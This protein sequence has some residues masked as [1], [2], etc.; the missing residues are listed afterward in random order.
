M[1]DDVDRKAINQKWSTNR[2]IE[3]AYKMFGNE[4]KCMRMVRKMQINSREINIAQKIGY[5]YKTC[6]NSL[7]MQHGWHSYYEQKQYWRYELIKK[8]I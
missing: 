3:D 8:Y 6:V 1:V 2:N 4:K 5:E 7:A